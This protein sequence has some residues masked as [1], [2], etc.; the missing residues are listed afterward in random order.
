MVQSYTCLVKREGNQYAS[1]CV[2]LD[3]ASCG[4]TKKAAISGLQDAIETYLAYMVAEGKESEI[5]RPVPMKE[6]RAFLF[7]ENMT[8]ERSLKAIPLQLQYA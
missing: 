3:V 6:L 2:E 1:L 4:Q 5:Y 8:E 7:P